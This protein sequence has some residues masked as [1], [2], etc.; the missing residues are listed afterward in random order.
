MSFKLEPGGLRGPN[1]TKDLG[2]WSCFLGSRLLFG[3]VWSLQFPRPLQTRLYAVQMN[4]GSY[5]LQLCLKTPVW[6]FSPVWI[7]SPDALGTEW[8]PWVNDSTIHPNKNAYKQF[9]SCSLAS[10]MDFFLWSEKN[11]YLCFRVNLLIKF[12]QQHCKGEM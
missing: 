1:G 6:I 10:D 5:H 12:S 8:F 3:S 2:L 9:S 11:N 7:S 4:P